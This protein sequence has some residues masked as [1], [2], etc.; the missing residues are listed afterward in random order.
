MHKT[1]SI[2]G[3]YG[4]GGGQMVRTASALSAITGIPCRMFNIRKNRKNP[5]L[6]QQHLI[7]L[8]VLAN[9]CNGDLEGG[10]LGSDE[11]IFYPGAIKAASLNVEIQTAGSITLALQTLL[12]PAFLAPEKVRINFHGGGT[13][14][15]FSPTMDYHRFV[16]LKILERMGL[17]ADIEIIKRGFYPKGGAIV[18]VEVQPHK[19]ANWNCIDRG[20]FRKV[21]ITSGASVDLKKS[22]V[23]ERQAK[24]AKDKLGLK[25]GLPIEVRIEYHS[26]LSTGSY[27]CIIAEFE[28]TYIGSDTLGRPGKRAE[29][30]GAEVAKV[31]LKEL[32]SGASLDKYAGDQIIP[33][34]ALA[35]GKSEFS[36]SE[37]QKHTTTNVWVVKHFLDREITFKPSGTKTAIKI[38]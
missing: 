32:Q 24:S 1:V 2:D 31:F 9:L 21:T 20:S 22:H 23:A 25:L 3:S 28:N 10:F 30:V 8:R 12:L 38:V 33:F 35:E 13:D 29:F 15:F 11:I 37:L 6:R 16:F 34:A 5:G 18:R 36:V 27:I 19:L 4:E 14:T 7:G 17:S 26:S